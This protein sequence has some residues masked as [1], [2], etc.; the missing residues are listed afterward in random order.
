M[1]K[2]SNIFLVL[3]F[4]VGSYSSTFG[5]IS[6]TI[7]D[8][9][10]EA[11]ST[12]MIPV[13]IDEITETDRQVFS[14]QFTIKYD[15]NVL[16]ISGVNNSGTISESWTSNTVINPRG[17]GEVDIGAF[18]IFNNILGKG[19]LIYL[20]AEIVGGHADS[21]LLELENFLFNAGDPQ[22]VTVNGKVRVVS[23]LV[24]ISFVSNIE[25]QII[26]VI[27][28]QE[29]TTPFDTTWHSGFEH[30][31]DVETPQNISSESRVIFDS[32]SDAGDTSHTVSPISDTVFSCNMRWEHLLSLTSEYGTALGGGWYAQGD[33]AEISVDSLVNSGDTTRYVFSGWQGFGQGSYTG[34][35]SV[36]K[37]VV[38]EPI[39]ENAQWIT[40]H[41]VT[42][43]SLFGN[44]VGD[45]WYVE[46]D[47][48]KIQIDSLEYINDQTRYLFNSW[49]GFGDGSYSGTSLFA[50]IIVNS[51]I[52]ESANW[53]KQFYL[54][55]LAT[56]EDI[57][58][59]NETG[60]YTENEPGIELIAPETIATTDIKYRFANWLIDG[61]IDN[62]NPIAV[63]MDTT[64][65][66][67]AIY[68]I[69]SVLVEIA[70]N[71]G[72]GLFIYV[73]NLKHITPY[74]EFW[75]YQ[76]EYTVGIDSVIIL[77]DSLSRYVFDLWDDGGNLFHSVKADSVIKLIAT[78]IPQ[79]Y[80]LVETEPSGLIEFEE[81]GWYV[82]GD[83]VQL[84]EA[85]PQ[86]FTESDTFQFNTWLVDSI[87][88]AGNP[89]N[90]NMNTHH[91]AVAN[92]E[93]LYFIAGKITDS[94]GMPVEDVEL[95]LSGTIEDT[96]HSKVTGDYFFSLLP[97]GNYQ[98][99]PHLE[100]FEF[101]P[102]FRE[103]DLLQSSQTEQDFLAVD[104]ID[105][106]VQLL[107][108][109]GG[110]W[111]KKSTTDT[112][113]WTAYDN[114]GIDSI[115]IE[116][117]L[118]GGIN[119]QTIAEIDSGNVQQF[120]WLVPDTVSKEC[121]IRVHVFDFD[122]N[123]AWDE[124]DSMFTIGSTT[125]VV[126][127]FETH[128]I[129][130]EFV[131]EQNYPNPF[132]NSTVIPFQLPKDSYVTVDIYNLGGQKV[133]TLAMKNFKAG[134]HRISWH[135]KNEFGKRVSTGVYLYRLEA[136]E[137]IIIKKLLYVR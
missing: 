67:N 50:D 3:L 128:L 136:L 45:G 79:H 134:S 77:P 60:W 64:H 109:N 85:L 74:S 117:A 126:E 93:N 122:N 53:D 112:I 40:Q 44:P 102:S 10:L 131:V 96:V 11:G 31:I 101:T 2:I 89:I 86:I 58:A 132:N 106:T 99:F 76:T 1:K 52:I 43:E 103:Y 80:L 61:E 26:F 48:V 65:I 32:W 62:Q 19:V 114:V 108:P 9:L 130:T 104:I 42:L 88:V 110:Q 5:Q 78:V 23:P 100:N 35:N 22:S 38:Y 83:S 69:D 120:V 119:W 57:T 70:T 15:E 29:K 39:V 118:D 124:S 63:Q 129:P 20:E 116:V 7:P 51:P 81:T 21:S 28:G 33:T 30:T 36:A 24:S 113:T 34:E 95:V 27:D 125:E 105:P 13:N 121:L 75:E 72:D 37:I 41:L 54:A 107:H 25:E 73:D 6:V 12:A 68:Q 47:T 59:F 98:V 4:A 17:G 82:E 127:R 71:A 14:F 133:K 8:T 46:G 49:E 87:P 111:L 115:A 123:N 56:P 16:N 55:V 97:Q 90:I 84:P 135:G 137:T 18:G 94:R 91:F 66:Y 92:Y